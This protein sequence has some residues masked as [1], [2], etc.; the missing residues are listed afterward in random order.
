VWQAEFKLYLYPE[1]PNYIIDKRRLSLRLKEQGFVDKVLSPNRFSVGDRF[2]SLLTFMG[3]SPDIELEPQ[4]NAPYCYV[5]FNID[6]KPHFIAGSNLKNA[7]CPH[8][9]RL[10]PRR[11]VNTASKLLIQPH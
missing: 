9:R 1:D 2:L 10:F 4:T 7:R 3:C 5:E 8:C 11:D 6:T